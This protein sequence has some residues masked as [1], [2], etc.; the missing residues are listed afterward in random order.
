MIGL[1]KITGLLL[2]FLVSYGFGAL[3]SLEL[4]KREENLR[5]I[6]ASLNELSSRIMLSDYKISELINL[7]FCE[8][9]VITDNKTGKLEIKGLEKGD[10]RLLEEFFCDLGMRDSKTEQERISLYSELF[11][12]R[13]SE[14]ISESASLCKLYNALG[15]LCG[16]FLCI[17]FL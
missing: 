13:L 11:K 15:V 8:N 9:T 14:A 16:I 7:C 5:G 2:V 3:K 17:F 10:K 1:F 12:G 4:K 6:V